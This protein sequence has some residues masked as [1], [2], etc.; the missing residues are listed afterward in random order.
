MHKIVKWLPTTLFVAGDGREF[1]TKEDC[2]KH[3]SFNNS[4]TLI[5]KL[6]ENR[7]FHNYNIPN[8]KVKGTVY[9]TLAPHIRSFDVTE[10]G[11]FML[12]STVF[13]KVS[14]RNGK[15]HL[16][17]V[18]SENRSKPH[19][20]KYLGWADTSVLNGPVSACGFNAKRNDELLAKYNMKML[21]RNSGLSKLTSEEVK[22]LNIKL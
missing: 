17:L 1:S 4:V 14:E 7:F 6:Y 8:V 10:E 5:R 21:W 16:L 19:E 12:S 15:I 13:V 11:F 22:A 18:T 3:E 2:E 20:W 9:E